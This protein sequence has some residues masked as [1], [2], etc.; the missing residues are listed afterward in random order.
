[1]QAVLG[2]QVAVCGGKQPQCGLQLLPGLGDSVSKRKEGGLGIP[3]R[4]MICA[5]CKREGMVKLAEDTLSNGWMYAHW[6]TERKRWQ[7][8]FFC[9]DCVTDFKSWM[10]EG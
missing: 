1:M 4:P 3:D 10:E 5:R 8:G 9:P 6:Y 2:L 7:A